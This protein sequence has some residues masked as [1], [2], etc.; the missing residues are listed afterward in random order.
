MEPAQRRSLAIFSTWVALVLDCTSCCGQSRV[1]QASSVSS[2]ALPGNLTAVLGL[3]VYL[4]STAARNRG[5]PGDSLGNVLLPAWHSLS[6]YNMY[7][8]TTS[9]WAGENSS[10]SSSQLGGGSTQAAPAGCTNAQTVSAASLPPKCKLI[11]ACVTFP[12]L[13]H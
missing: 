13:A 10:K 8:L 7:V 9:M 4:L 2:V 11:M 1:W 3:S 6:S 12:G 5:C